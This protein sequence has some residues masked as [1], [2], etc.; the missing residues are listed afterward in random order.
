MIDKNI[1][2]YLNQYA[3]DYPLEVLKDQLK[4]SGYSLQD[5]EDGANFIQTG[6]L[7]GPS[8][9][10][11]VAIPE[12]GFPWLWVAVGGIAVV[13][14][15]GGAIFLFRGGPKTEQPSG[16][17]P[18]VNQV[19]TPTNVVTPTGNIL[20]GT[21]CNPLAGQKV[22]EA[23]G[24]ISAKYNGKS[25]PL[26]FDAN[27]GFPETPQLDID[28]LSILEPSLCAEYDD[29][30]SAGFAII[31]LH[32]ND[33]PMVKLILLQFKAGTYD[34]AANS[35]PDYGNSEFKELAALT[36]SV[37][38]PA[39]LSADSQVLDLVGGKMLVG[40][41]PVGA[42][43]EVTLDFR[44]VKG[45][46]KK[47]NTMEFSGVIR[48][49]L[50]GKVGMQTPQFLPSCSSSGGELCSRDK[51][52]SFPIVSKDNNSQQVCCRKNYC[53]VKSQF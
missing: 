26:T 33:Q 7:A 19:T 4:N 40:P 24:S 12:A 23:S 47:N 51:N 2:D 6:G 5:I 41:N 45:T 31:H 44:G 21:E 13:A 8:A 52:C 28:P 34:F 46:T 36:A 1:V 14:L 43:V 38:D 22:L 20:A 50:P 16:T 35:G 29:K 53:G 27:K 25:Y 3:K 42:G 17:T 15:I 11:A 37:L 32:N 10:P 48:F 18:P 39:N 30:K 9:V 49:K